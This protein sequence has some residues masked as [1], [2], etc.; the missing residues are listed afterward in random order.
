MGTGG[1]FAG[2]KFSSKLI[3]QLYGIN[4]IALY[5]RDLYYRNNNSVDSLDEMNVL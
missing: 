3:N 4:T 2:A 5:P 1:S